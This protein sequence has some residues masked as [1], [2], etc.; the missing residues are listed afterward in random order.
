M[1]NEKERDELDTWH[2]NKIICP[3]CGYEFEESWEYETGGEIELEETECYDCEKTFHLSIEY[4]VQYTTTRL[5]ENE[6]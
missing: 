6:L 2:E 4:D 1:S 3:Y 5:E